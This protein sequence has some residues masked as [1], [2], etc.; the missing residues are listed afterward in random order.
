MPAGRLRQ[1]VSETAIYGLSSILA[2]L[3]NFLLFP[4]YSHVF[5]PDA[6][7]VI[8]IVYTAFLFFNIVYQ[9]GMESAYLRFAV[10]ASKDRRRRVF[11]TAVGSLLG[12]SLL[13]SL[14]IVLFPTPIA[15]L[16]DLEARYRWLLY[17]MA[18]ILLLDTLAIIPFAEL[19]LSNRAWRFALIRLASVCVNLG[20]NIWLLVGLHWGVAGVFMANAVASATT[21]AL[22]SPEFIR[23][24]RPWFDRQLWRDLLRFGLPFLPGGLGY[25][26][27]DRINLLFL[28][29]MTPDQVRQ[30]YHERLDL[31]ALAREAER[32]AQAVLERAGGMLTPEVQQR[33]TEA[34]QAVYG[35]HVVGV[36]NGVLKLAIF[37][38]L[39]IQMFRFAWQPF[40]LQHARDPDAPQ[41]F[42]R[43]FL[44]LTAA[45]LLVLLSVSFF[46]QEIVQLPLPGGYALINPR[47]WTGLFIV[48]VALL[49][50]L[51]QGWYYVFSAGAYLRHR[52]S[53]FIPATLA[54]ALVSLLL[55]AL[56]VPRM[57]MLGAAWATTLAY[58]TMALT[59]WGLIRTHYAVPY[60]W[61]QVFALGAWTL[62]IFGAWQTWPALQQPVVELLLLMG[63]AAALPTLRVVTPGELRA[64][65]VRFPPSA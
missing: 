9:Y 36:Y 60:P 58:A 59:L 34:A 10:H 25:A 55:N 7:G 57:G 31:A 33:M 30:L 20:L 49:G 53:L 27:T 15:T 52:T 23:L 35:N 5:S 39:V 65:F 14:L 16:I 48:P 29:R 41:L 32:A 13:L 28:K 21:L 56:L 24:W 17:Y 3:F 40:F 61:R 63:W 8:S 22:L 4:F 11:S 19:R 64:L 54:G 50:Y 38:M 46:A 47:Y 37:L 45:S 2:R 1:L 12:S 42:A 44:L 26:I 62:L 43:V 51:F 6:Y 18:V